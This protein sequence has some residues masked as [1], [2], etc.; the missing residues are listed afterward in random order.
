MRA[1]IFSDSHGDEE[2]L[3]WM[4]ELMSRRGP[5]NAYVHCGDGAKDFERVENYL[6]TLSP[7]ARIY[8]VRGNCDYFVHD[9]PDQRVMRLG[10]VNVLITHGHLYGVKTTLSLLPRPAKE[11]GCSVVLFGHTHRP[12]LEERDGILLMNP[13]T[14]QRGYA[15]LLTID[16]AGKPKGEL[17]AF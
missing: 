10:T 15:A 4:A 11:L 17:L 9:V 7:Q 12:T 3:R 13:G 14:A 2:N 6:L 8:G 16:E 1:L 5:V